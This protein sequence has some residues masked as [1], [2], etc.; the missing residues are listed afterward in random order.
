[1]KK[2]LFLLAPL[3]LTGLIACGETTNGE[4]N[5]DN[6]QTTSGDVEIFMW[7]NSN[8]TT[9]SLLGNFVT[10]F[11]AE[12]PGIKVTLKKETGDY[13]AILN[14]TLTG[15]TANNYPD[16][17]LGYPDSVS[18]IMD[19]GKVV[20]LDKY[21]NDPEVGWTQ[22][23]LDD[24]PEA[25]IE[26]GRNYQIEGTYSLPYAKSTEAMY[27]NKVLIGLDL[28]TQN[29]QINNGQPLT[30]DYLNNLTWEELFNKL[31]PALV[32]YNNQL[33]E[34]QKIWLPNDKG[35]ESIVSW[36]SDSNAFITLCEQYGYDYTQLDKDTGK[37]RP[38]FNNDDTKALMKT[39]Y[40]AHANKYFTT[41]KAAGGSYTNSLFAKKQV[42]FD[43]GS[44]GGGQYYSG[45]NNTLVDFQIAKIPHAEGKAAKV[46]NQGPSLAILKHDDDRA[47][48]SWKFYKFITNKKN[49]DA[50]ARTTGYS[51]IRYSVYE[52][53]DWADY[54]SLEGKA[55]KSL[56]NTYAQIAQYVPKVS[57]DLY[58][59]PVFNGSATCRTQVEGLMG[60]ILNM[61]TWTDEE[62]NKFF[63]S[64]YETSL[65]AC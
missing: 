65:L 39:F 10:A 4:G 24:I 52:S 63:K 8:D 40:E 14:A 1:M 2:K 60:N 3:V 51:P 15:L 37:G 44:T 55:S 12:N 22:E 20:N 30:E 48:A 7:H 34:G 43:I 27:Y 11:E 50:F 26:E 18:Q 23:D 17:F 28:S 59:S 49:A 41:N 56:E 64:A 36:S 62:A 6:N 46:I 42:L 13:N 29:A 33:A 45:S 31:C 38:T 61:K 53:S 25:Y 58:S 47:L 5:G 19:Y 32:A 21:I 16:L 54:S 57:N 35:Y 9:A